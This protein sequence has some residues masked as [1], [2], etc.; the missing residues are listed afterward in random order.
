[1]L[2]GQSRF[3]D[4]VQAE[5][6]PERLVAGAAL[7]QRADL[8]GARGDERDVALAD[9][10]LLRQEARAQERLADLE[11]ERALVAREAAREVAELGVV[12]AV[13]AHAVEAAQHAARRAPARQR[14][15]GDAGV[16]AGVLDERRS[17]AGRRPP[18]P[19]ARTPRR[20]G[21]RRGG[22]PSRRATASAPRRRA[23]SRR[24]R[25]RAAARPRCARGRAPARDPRASAAAAR[26]RRRAPDASRRS[27]IQP[28]QRAASSSASPARSGRRQ[29]GR[30]GE[31]RGGAA[32]EP[33]GARGRRAVGG[34]RDD[35][36][37]AVAR[38]RVDDRDAAGA[39]VREQPAPVVAQRL[40]HDRAP[41]GGPEQRE[42]GGI[43]RL[44]VERRA[45][46]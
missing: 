37:D 25:R 9:R 41:L 29:P 35:E 5:Q 8:G 30:L 44:A 31:R 13:L 1:M 4:A 32:R 23:R 6:A 18:R 27:A 42:C 21:G 36:R 40:E 10:R 14:I 2:R 34:H 20:P 39:R 19:R 16:D 28:C 17:R 26:A 15:V 11:R 3:R 46:A 24:D 7:D 43:H 12:A 45:R 33:L 22:R 38:L